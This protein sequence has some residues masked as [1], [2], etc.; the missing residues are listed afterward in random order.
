MC[1][2]ARL[3]PH[4]PGCG[5]RDAYGTQPEGV[6]QRYVPG[7]GSLNPGGGS[8]RHGTR[9]PWDA[10]CRVHHPRMPCRELQLDHTQMLATPWVRSHHRQ[11]EQTQVRQGGLSARIL[12]SCRLQETH[13]LHSVMQVSTSSKA[14][15][16]TVSM[17]SADH[18]QSVALSYCC[19]W[20]S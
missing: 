20:Q 5:I 6:A 18:S 3:I 15:I 11:H 16:R 2:A 17:L 7:Y 14:P 12:V 1:L 8:T 13:E 9:R 19:K 4:Q 10:V